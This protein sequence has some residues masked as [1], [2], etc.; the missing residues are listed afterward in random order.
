MLGIGVPSASSGASTG[1]EKAVTVGPGMQDIA[2]GEKWA[3]L[4]KVSF[5]AEM[6]GTQMGVAIGELVYELISDC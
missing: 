5:T 6:G 3:G 1:T 2:M 4:N